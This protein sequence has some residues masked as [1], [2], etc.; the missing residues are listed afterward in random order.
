MKDLNVF[1][2]EFEEEEEQLKSPLAREIEE[3]FN[4]DAV[5]AA[6][7]F[8]NEGRI[9]DAKIL[10]ELITDEAFSILSSSDYVALCENIINDLEA[11][12]E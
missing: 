3:S 11:E 1:E 9:E 7:Y 8:L 2:E 5:S 4:G 10:F 12:F 6:M